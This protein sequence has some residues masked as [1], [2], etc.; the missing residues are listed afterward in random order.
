MPKVL[1][2]AG[3]EE[4]VTVCLSCDLSLSL[5]LSLGP[6]HQQISEMHA[7]KAESVANGADSSKKK[8]LGTRTLLSWPYY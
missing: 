1:D 2:D 3:V 4:T 5:S 6:L 8:L 7:G